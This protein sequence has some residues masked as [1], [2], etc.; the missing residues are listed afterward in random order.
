[1][2]ATGDG[3]SDIQCREAGEKPLEYLT[4][5]DATGVSTVAPSDGGTSSI[6][7]VL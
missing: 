2:A 7:G 3:S 6:I 1:M 5:G 4:A